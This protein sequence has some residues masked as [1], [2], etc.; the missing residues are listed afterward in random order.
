MVTTAR[1]TIVC[2]F[3]FFLFMGIKLLIKN[4]RNLHNFPDCTVFYQDSQFDLF[5]FSFLV[6]STILADAIRNQ[7]IPKLNCFG[8]AY[9]MPN[10]INA[11]PSAEN[12]MELLKNFIG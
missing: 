3:S 5:T 6:A 11:M 9:I 8:S 1:R 2:Y 7:T 4:N 10:V 12:G